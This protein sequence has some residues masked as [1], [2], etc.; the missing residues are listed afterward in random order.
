MKGSV[1]PVVRSALKRIQQVVLSKHNELPISLHEPD[2]RGTEAWSYV[3]DCID[4][5]WVS[6]AGSWVKR[7]EQDLCTCTGA[8]HAVVVSNGTVALRLSLHLVGVKPRDEVLLPP[9]SF[10]ATANAVAHL[11]AVPHFVDVE[12]EALGLCPDALASR[13]VAIADKREAACSTE[14]GRR[15][16]AVVPV[17][18]FGNPAKVDQIRKITDRWGLPIEDAAEALEAGKK[19]HIVAY[20]DRSDTQLQW[21]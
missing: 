14:T 3:K 6:T 13:L 20:L 12:R 10:V 11:G 1:S 15:I 16:A 7:F 2:F 21:K 18:I 4:S 9:L 5:G 8:S 19:V 17:H